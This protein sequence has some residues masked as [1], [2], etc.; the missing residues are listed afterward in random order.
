MGRACSGRITLPLSS[1]FVSL[2]GAARW[3]G[4]G[5]A[6]N[7]KCGSRMT[8]LR[9][10]KN[11]LKTHGGARDAKSGVAPCSLLQE[12]N[13]GV[14]LYTASIIHRAANIQYVASFLRGELILCWQRLSE[15]P[16]QGLRLTVPQTHTQA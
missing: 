11:V 3:E 6:L 13:G 14:L 12:N 7:K 1:L 10:N 8:D 15:R 5:P 4:G 16:T 9:F 2:S